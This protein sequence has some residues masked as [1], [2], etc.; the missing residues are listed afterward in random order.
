VHF[1]FLSERGPLREILLF[2]AEKI[3]KINES[4]CHVK[5]DVLLPGFLYFLW[6]NTMEYIF[7]SQG[8]EGSC[9]FSG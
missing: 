3:Q 7:G 2:F 4:V 5:G 8:V 6:I 1:Q 9:T